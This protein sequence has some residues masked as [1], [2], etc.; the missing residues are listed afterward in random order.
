MIKLIKFFIWLE[1]E[2]INAMIHS[3]EGIY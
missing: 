3:G 1:K 2:K